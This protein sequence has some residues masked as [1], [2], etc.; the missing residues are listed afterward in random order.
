MNAQLNVDTTKSPAELVKMLLT[1]ERQVKVENV[2]YRGLNSSRG[3]FTSQM[4]YNKMI[5]RG[6]VLSTGKAM[7]VRGPNDEPNLTYETFTGG[8]MQLE[9]IA[10]GKTFDVV[11]LEFDFTP[12]NDSIGFNY[13]FASEEYPEYVNKKVNDVFAFFLSCE[14]LNFEANLA[15]LPDQTPITVDNINEKKNSKY[16]IGNKTW[17]E[18]NIQQWANNKAGGELAFTFQMDGMTI[19]LK[20]GSRVVPGKKY[21]IKLAIADVGDHLFD[22][23]IFLQAGSF[24][25]LSSEVLSLE[26]SLSKEFGVQVKKDEDKN[27]SVDLNI[28]FDPDSFRVTDEA[29][30]EMLDKVMEV[31]IKD[32][33]LNLEVRGH[34]D[35]SG[36]KE[37]NKILSLDRAKSVAD[38]LLE[39]G[40]ESSRINYQGFGDERPVSIINKNLNRRVEFVFLKKE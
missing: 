11:S 21:H 35:D 27:L 12:V 15:L 23:A 4:S 20:A 29:S 6:L 37:H 18:G 14:E 13:F 39:K 31:L 36:T 9:A 25:S 30:F 2:S 38:Y 7:E 19:L 32:P 34:T 22:S 3:L 8:D 1:N 26:E 28:H 5:P 24:M 40:I 10:K 17:Y 16:F 33:Q